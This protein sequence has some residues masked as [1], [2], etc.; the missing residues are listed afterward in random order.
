MIPRTV[1][2]V[3]FYKFISNIPLISSNHFFQSWLP[4]KSAGA[5]RSI[6]SLCDPKADAKRKKK[7]AKAGGNVKKPK[8]KNP[9]TQPNIAGSLEVY[10][11][12]REIHRYQTRVEPCIRRGPFA[13]QAKEVMLDETKKKFRIQAVALTALQEATESFITQMFEA[14]SIIAIHAKRQTLRHKDIERLK[15]ILSIFYSNSH[16][17]LTKHR[18]DHKPT[19]HHHSKVMKPTRKTP[20]GKTSGA[21][22]LVRLLV[23]SRFLVIPRMEAL[24]A[25]EMEAHRIDQ[26]ESL[27]VSLARIERRRMAQS[28]ARLVIFAAIRQ[29][30]Y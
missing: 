5:A 3:P 19:E 13:H 27:A 9:P 2:S 15:Q 8:K 23:A 11:A 16:Q 10:V 26:S 4:P 6:L 1:P 12:I 25:M 21:R 22:L 29:Q 18:W 14:S 20:G 7:Q 30:G 24:A 17:A 28:E